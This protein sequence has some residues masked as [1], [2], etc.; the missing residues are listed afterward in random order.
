[1]LL[2]SFLNS[3]RSWVLFNFGWKHSTENV[4]QVGKA[5]LHPLALGL[6][7]NAG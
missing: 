4:S 2:D 7:Y 1:M 5:G 6:S 3:E